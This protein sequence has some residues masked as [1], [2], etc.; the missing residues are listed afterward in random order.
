M[1]TPEPS[2]PHKPAP[3][4]T[5]SATAM[6]RLEV[7]LPQTWEEY[8][9][10]DSGGG[11]KLERY[12]AYTFI[13]PEPQAMWQPSLPSRAWQ[14]A[15]AEFIPSREESGGNWRFSRPV[16]ESWIM[17]YPPL[18]F[19]V[20]TTAGR[21]LGV[22]PEQ[23]VQWD[24]ISE[25]LNAAPR[26]PVKVL[27]LFAY[28]GLAS[29]AAAHAGAQVTHV[30]ASKKSVA[31]A[32]RNQELSAMQ[33][34]PIRWIVDDALKFVEREA[35]RGNLYEGL[36]LDPPKFGRG[37]KGEVWEFFELFPRLLEACRTVLA[38]QPVLVVI[39]A[40]AIRASA[41]CLYYQLSEM[42]SGFS[43]SVSAG[44][45]GIADSS[46]GRVISMALFARWQPSALP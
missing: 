18:S 6:P 23:A 36:I 37:P 24:W 9:L 45:I 22:F 40:Y 44:E 3:G 28:T 35:R 7:L 15:H 19:Q 27:N 30:D 8:A 2:Q 16:E 29:L 14:T 10:L 33:A 41:L 1:P 12:G 4:K 38:P 43:G 46:S 42:M 13:R 39:T 31:W 32:R 34:L 17:N 26:K 20:Q 25:K 11:R 5:S 21:H